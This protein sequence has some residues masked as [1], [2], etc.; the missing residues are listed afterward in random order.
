ML[1]SLTPLIRVLLEGMIKP[2]GEYPERYRQTH[3][4]RKA[5]KTALDAVHKAVEAAIQADKATRWALQTAGEAQLEAAR[6]AASESARQTIVRCLV[7]RFGEEAEAIE[8][9]LEMIED[10]DILREL[11]EFAGACSDLDAF[12]AELDRRT[13]EGSDPAADVNP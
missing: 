6:Q 11:A 4:A 9:E 7:G 12:R 1:D 8:E 5:A 2:E 10:G 3:R 13:D